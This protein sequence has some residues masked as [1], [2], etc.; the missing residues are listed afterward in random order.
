M[1]TNI[2]DAS[3]GSSESNFKNSIFSRK[4]GPS[5]SLNS[6]GKNMNSGHIGENH[7]GRHRYG[8]GVDSKI[9]FT[10]NF[11]AVFVLSLIGGCAVSADIELKWEWPAD[12]AVEDRIL[13]KVEDIKPQGS[14]FFGFK[15]SPS[16]ASNLPEPTVIT[17][18]IQN[19]D[20][21]IQGKSLKIIV[22][23]PEIGD[24]TI[25]GYAVLGIVEN[26]I[27]IC[28]VPVASAEADIKQ[29]NCP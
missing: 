3:S 29:V 27:C 5:I 9:S 10:T 11:I 19:T 25:G 13:I 4:D 7:T 2:G 26:D 8:L 6:T 14:G 12:R 21:L 18:T 20:D 22:P 1:E 16:F 15:K 28:I 17:G 23:K 24:T